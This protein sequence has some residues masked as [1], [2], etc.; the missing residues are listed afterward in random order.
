MIAW[1]RKVCGVALTPA[2][3]AYLE[4]ICCT[5]LVLNL[6]CLWVWKS[7]R[8]L[9]VGGDVRPQ[10]GGE[11]LAEEDVAVLAALALV[12]PDLA[13]FE[14]NFGDS[15]VAEFTDPHRET[16]PDISSTSSLYRQAQNTTPWSSTRT[17][18]LVS[19][20]PYLA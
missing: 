4:T 1:C 10:G 17:L 20:R 14:I 15:E 5:L 12:H 7:Q 19:T 16:E 3:S 18:G 11:G 9:R 6:P 13:G 2:S 8:L